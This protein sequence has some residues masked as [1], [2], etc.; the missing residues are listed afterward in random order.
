MS[1]LSASLHD[2]RPDDGRHDF[3]FYFGRWRLRNERLKARLAGSQEWE[4]F[5]ATQECRPILGGLG[6]LDDFVTEWGGGYRG[7][8]LRLFQPATQRW[9]IYWA[10]NRDGVLGS[11]VHGRFQ[12][13]VGTFHGRDEHEG[14]PVLV[15]YVWSGITAERAHWAQAFSTDEGETWE[16]NWR[17]AMTRVGA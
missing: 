14:T 9:S 10:S 1:N 8:T 11:P 5:E 17:M 15:R 7:M 2:A 16:E 13:G 6:N 4:V 3:D 12:D